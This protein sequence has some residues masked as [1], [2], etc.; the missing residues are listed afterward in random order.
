MLCM[1]RFGSSVGVRKL[2]DEPPLGS[3]SAFGLDGGTDEDVSF[4]GAHTCA[5]KAFADLS[6]EDPRAL[7]GRPAKRTMRSSPHEGSDRNDQGMANVPLA[8]ARPRRQLRVADGN[9]LHLVVHEEGGMRPQPA[10]SGA[11]ACQTATLSRSSPTRPRQQAWQR[12]HTRAPVQPFV[13]NRG[14]AP[15]TRDSGIRFESFLCQG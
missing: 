11:E 15:C 6:A 9:G 1:H 10:R 2:S 12:D 5:E 4:S 7:T 8:G 13:V 14:I 3:G